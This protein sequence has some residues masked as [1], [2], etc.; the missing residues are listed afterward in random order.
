MLS[1]AWLFL[2]GFISKYWKYIAVGLAVL[3][4]LYCIKLGYDHIYEKGYN[5]A[6][7]ERTT[8]YEGI[9]KQDNEA[10]IT[11]IDGIEKLSSLQGQLI[12][13][14]QDKLI[15]GMDI[16]TKNINN[17]KFYKVNVTTGECAPSED[18]IK[19]FNAI[20]GKANEKTNSN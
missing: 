14:K 18:F 15:I 11:K 2:K 8:H 6:Y 13:A 4:V 19:T 12:D 10:L 16:I 5:V 17:K 7:Q 1:I 3:A 9:R 20:I